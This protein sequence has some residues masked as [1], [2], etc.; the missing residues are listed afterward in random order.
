MGGN[1]GASLVT[2]SLDVLFWVR[3]LRPPQCACI[4][5]SDGAQLAGAHEW[6]YRGEGNC[7]LVVGLQGARQI[8]RIRKTEKPQS[9][10]GWILV[11]LTDLIEWCSGKACGDEAR[12]LAFYCQVMRPLI[13]AHY[14]S[15]ARMVA[16]SRPQLQLILEGV[17]QR[18]PDHRRH[19]TLQLGRAALFS[20]FAFLPPRFDHL[21]FIG[22][23]F[24]V[25]LKPKQG[26]RPPKERL[27]L[28]QCLYCMHQLL[29]LQTGRVQGR[30]DYCPEELFSGDPGRMRRA[31]RHLLAAPQNNLKIFRNGAQCFDDRRRSLSVLQ[32]LFQ[33]AADPLELADEFCAL[34]QRC[35]LLDLSGTGEG[36]C[37]HCPPT[38]L[39]PGCVLG[40][41]LSAQQLDQEGTHSTYKKLCKGGQSGNFDYVDRVLGALAAQAQPCMRCALGRI[42]RQCA[43]DLLFAPYLVAAVAKDCSL[44]VTLRRV[45]HSDAE[46]QGRTLGT[47]YGAFVVNVGVF[48]LYPK[49]MD[50]I[51]KHQRRNREIFKALKRPQVLN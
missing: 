50:T 46:L 47:P 13:G 27:A 40:R 16:L 12:D 7:N 2:V 18:R 14:T 35:L 15:E 21:D 39:P 41:I 20:D 6:A 28:P 9:L 5:G 4:M 17:R 31:L 48:D 26:W 1:T 43:L 33:S 42:A 44:M 49:P 19:K 34:L 36:Q 32:E 25:E 45:P 37:P 38:H 22:D 24:A 30:T 3:G 29:K 11:L 51:L 8:L 23:T 10:L